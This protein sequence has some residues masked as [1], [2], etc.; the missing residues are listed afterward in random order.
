MAR[1][2]L[3]LALFL[4]ASF[5]LPASAGAASNHRSAAVSQAAGS[6]LAVAAANARTYWGAAP[7]NGR[8]TILV[9]SPL[10]PS[11][12]RMTSAWATFDSSQGAN[13]LDAPANSYTNCAISL[14]RWRWPTTQ[15]MRADWDVLCSTVIHETGHLLGHH[16]DTTPGSVMTSAFTDLSSEPAICRSKRPRG[17]K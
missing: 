17:S 8:I 9:R 7:C 1:C 4:A 3:H 12:S 15:S 5:V 14:A 6:P 11:V 16:H 10:A 2:Y 13:N